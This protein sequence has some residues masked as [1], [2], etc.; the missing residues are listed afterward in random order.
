MHEIA[1]DDP[2]VVT[3]LASLH[4]AGNDA[5]A[6]VGVLEAQSDSKHPEV[7][8]RLGEALFAADRTKEALAV[9]QEVHDYYVAAL[10]HASFVDNPQEIQAR[11]AE[12]VRLR[13]AVV[14]ELHGSEATIET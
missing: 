8:L 12:T 11:L 3:G 1:P 14:A 6:A 13:D 10:K 5:A 7:R 4:L 9:L 2:A